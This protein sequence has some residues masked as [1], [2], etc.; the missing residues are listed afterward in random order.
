MTRVLTKGSASIRRKKTVSVTPEPALFQQARNAGINLSAVLTEALKHEIR[1]SE[2]ERW[3]KN[4][5]AL[6]E[7]NRIT[8]KHGL[9]SDDHRV[10]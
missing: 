2:S 3:K 8:D 1:A 10:F 6:Q 7:L 9:L 4:H 5:K